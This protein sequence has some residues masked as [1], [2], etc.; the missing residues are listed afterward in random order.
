MICK[1]L[2]SYYNTI[3]SGLDNC[4]Y[5]YEY[6]LIIGRL[7]YLGLAIQRDCYACIHRSDFNYC[8]DCDDTSN[9]PKYEYKAI[10]EDFENC[11]NP[12]V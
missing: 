9:R 12:E 1:E 11:K 2:S 7:R 3:N 5:S 10:Y 4:E 8:G 6:G